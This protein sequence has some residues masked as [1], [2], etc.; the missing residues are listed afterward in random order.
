MFMKYIVLHA[1]DNKTD[2]A[3][4]GPGT[5]LDEETDKSKD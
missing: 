4:L 5:Q 3:E 2:Q 1:R